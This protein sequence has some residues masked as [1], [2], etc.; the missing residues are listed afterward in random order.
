MASGREM[1]LSM[2]V[3]LV[4]GRFVQVLYSQRMNWERGIRPVKMSSCEVWRCST[5][6]SSGSSECQHFYKI[7]HS[8]NAHEKLSSFHCCEKVLLVVCLWM[9]YLL[10]Y[11]TEIKFSLCVHGGG[12][13]A[14]SIPTDRVLE[15]A[16]RTG[17]SRKL[18]SKIRRR[19]DV[20]R[21]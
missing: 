6:D 7:E 18:K 17:P 1:R 12:K 20:C 3:F 2:T 21:N 13:R 11:F 14:W 4:K 10:W 19:M 9:V 15:R 16:R 8:D 5:C